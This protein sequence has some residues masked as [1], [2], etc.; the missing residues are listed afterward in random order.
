MVS[1][2]TLTF[3][4][5]VA[6]PSSEDLLIQKL[7]PSTC[8]TLSPFHPFLCLFSKFESDLSS[9]L[10]ACSKVYDGENSGSLSLMFSLLYF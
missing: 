9:P 1:S 8:R 4:N 6:E 2:V 10:K 5:I 7:W 3:L